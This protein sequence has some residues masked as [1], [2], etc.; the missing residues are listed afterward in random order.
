[1]QTLVA[2]LIGIAAFI[3]VIKIFSKQLFQSEKNSKC[4]NCPVPEIINKKNIENLK[5]GNSNK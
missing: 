1:M 5:T 4:E 2:I 3:Y